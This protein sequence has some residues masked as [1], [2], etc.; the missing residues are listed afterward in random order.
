ML[1]QPHLPKGATVRQCLEKFIELKLQEM[2]AV[3]RTVN[4]AFIERLSQMEDQ[5]IAAGEGAVPVNSEADQSWVEREELES[6]N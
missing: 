5:I 4:Q 1:A 3:A 6:K 2:D